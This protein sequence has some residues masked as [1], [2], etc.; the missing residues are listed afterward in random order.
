MRIK[1]ALTGLLFAGMLA[2]GT[3]QAVLLNRGGGLIYDTDLNITWLADAN[4]EQKNGGM[5]WNEAI[6]WA[7]NLTYGGYSDWRLPKLIQPDTTCSGSDIF[8]TSIGFGCTGGEMGHLY[9]SEL[10]DGVLSPAVAMMKLTLQNSGHWNVFWYGTPY[11]P[12]LL[13]PTTETIG[14]LFDFSNGFTGGIN[15]N[16]SALYTWAVRDGDSAVQPIE[17]PASPEPIP[18]PGSLALFGLALG[19]LAVS[20]RKR[21]KVN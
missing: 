11:E 10:R 3:A 7:S 1:A 8:V 17:E 15:K 21:P 12:N 2:S 20:R 18:E 4:H 9:Y 19:G 13:N 6:L 14:L 16:E 5:H